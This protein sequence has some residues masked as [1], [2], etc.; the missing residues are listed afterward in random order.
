M[1][2]AE[3][4]PHRRQVATAGRFVQR[5]VPQFERTAQTWFLAP[6]L[7]LATIVVPVGSVSASERFRQL[8]S[9]R[10]GFSPT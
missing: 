6:F 4:Q 10:C 1:V 8:Q 3:V 2:P 5:V 7:V 9:Q